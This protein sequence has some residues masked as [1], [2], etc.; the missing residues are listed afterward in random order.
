MLYVTG[1]L[2]LNILVFPGVHFPY[3]WTMAYHKISSDMTDCSHMDLEDWEC[4]AEVCDYIYGAFLM[5]IISIH[6]FY[7]TKKVNT[8]NKSEARIKSEKWS[9]TYKQWWKLFQNGY[10]IKKLFN[11]SSLTL[12]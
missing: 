9:Q 8:A 4:S 10:I 1:L 3:S 12:P 6:H 2:L 11:E 7:N 5:V